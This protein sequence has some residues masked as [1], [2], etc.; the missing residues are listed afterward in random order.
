MNEELLLYLAFQPV[1]TL[2]GGG[3]KEEKKV[4]L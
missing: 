4:K 1:I 3:G 2:P